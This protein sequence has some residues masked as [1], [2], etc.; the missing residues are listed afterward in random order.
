MVK[1]YRSLKGKFLSIALLTAMLVVSQ[2]LLFA[3][4]S[5][6][7]SDRQKSILERLDIELQEGETFDEAMM[8]ARQERSSQKAGARAIQNQAAGQ[9]SPEQQAADARQ[10]AQNNSAQQDQNAQPDQQELTPDQ[11]EAMERNREAMEKAMEFLKK[12]RQQR[13]EAEEMYPEKF[14][15]QNQPQPSRQTAESQTAPSDGK[16][17]K[18][19]EPGGTVQATQLPSAEQA[20]E[21]DFN[22]PEITDSNK[23]LNLSVTLP[24]KVEITSLIELVGK[25]LGLN[26]IYD[27]NKVRG[28][29]MLKVHN[30]KIKVKDLY[31]LLE[32]VLKFRGFIMTRR[33]NLVTIVTKN[34][35]SE[36]DPA[37]VEG[38]EDVKPGDVIITRVFKLE[39]INT[40]S[41]KKMLMSMKLGISIV[42]LPETKSLIVTG[43]SYRMPRIQKM[44][45]LVDVAGEKRTFE[46]R[47]LEYTLAS[48]LVDKVEALAQ[49]LGTVDVTVS[50]S[51]SS[52]RQPV[53]RDSKGRI[54]PNQKNGSSSSTVGQGKTEGVYLDVDDRTNRILMI[55]TEDEIEEVNSLIEAFDVPKQDLRKI[56]QY[57]IEFVG[58]E[59]VLDAL[60]Q[61]GIV[62]GQ[63]SS[64]SRLAAARRNPRGSTQ[65]KSNSPS[66]AVIED[67]KEVLEDEPQVVLLETSNSLLV[68]ATDE[69]HEKID[70]IIGYIDAE[71]EEDA[72]PVK[73]YPL[74]NQS[75]QDIE[76]TLVEV[77]ERIAKDKAEKA[78][79]AGQ[80]S[81]GG[82]SSSRGKI[83]K[84][85]ISSRGA[86]NTE[87]TITGDEGTNSIIVY[88]NKKDQD[89]I[90]K[91]ITELDKK[92]PQVLIDVTLVEVSQKDEFEYDLDVAASKN[93]L[94]DTSGA[95]SAPI[96]AGNVALG[97][98]LE[99]RWDTEND[100]FK[101]FYSDSDIQSLLTVMQKKNYGR[102]MAKPKLLVN[103]NQEGTIETTTTTYKP[104]TQT[105]YVGDENPTAVESQTWESYNAGVN[106]TITPHISEGDLLR[107]EI[108]VN[109]TD[110]DYSTS[111][112]SSE[113]P[114]DE[115]KSD[116]KTVVTVPDSSTIIL[117]GLISINQGKGGS[118]VPILGD[119]PLVGA[120]FKTVSNSDDQSKLYVFVKAN[121]LRPTTGTETGLDD[122]L[123]QSELQRES[124]EEAEQNFHK[125]QDFPGLESEQMAPEKVL[126]ME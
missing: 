121:I 47:R 110:F 23:Q 55:G 95:I 82:T 37:I 39:H 18:Q 14:E 112:S 28:E 80:G 61:L 22:V 124:F 126:E 16:T 111:S 118:K 93:G 70:S 48:S 125:Y 86:G 53:R 52:Q 2:H 75:V 94:D 15:Q 62:A 59:V 51:S 25:Q 120:L 63:D 106:L 30:G 109:R 24:E 108:N 100:K 68:N 117:G 114:Y 6:E 92:R 29:V 50:S 54:I 101:G 69:Q 9:Q 46:Y 89:W 72:A 105:D 87:V 99:G 90:E 96:D 1:K 43:Y 83:Q 104:Q 123:E 8:R 17:L 19:I 32:S 102:I 74:E 64:Q 4:E 76:E 60:E 107:L 49:N 10:T 73:V 26:Y 5:E 36:L 113:R 34:E 3:Q 71:P 21:G 66:T 85:S 116:V 12:A 35:A 98:F 40:D 27:Q 115:I 44:L 7:I 42:D 103:D 58:A 38:D 56:Q 13:Q 41:A 77:V 84:T 88:A 31:G 57:D 78:G 97:N 67:A 81:S 119:L 91:L 33:G 79:L 122:L 65:Q 20:A 11:R 45:S